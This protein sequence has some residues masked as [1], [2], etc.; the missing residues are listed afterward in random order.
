MREVLAITVCH[1][2][3]FL[4]RLLGRNGGTTPGEIALKIAPSILTRLKYPA[5]Y[6]IVTGTNGKTSV[7]GMIR[8]I[9]QYAG[10][11]VVSNVHGDNLIFGA[12]SAILARTDWNRRVRGDAVVLELDEMTFARKV[13]N[14][15]PTDVVLTNFFRDQLDRCGE[16]ASIVRAV[17]GAVE[18]LQEE[19]AIRV[20]L[21]ADDPSLSAF[22]GICFGMGENRFSVQ[23]SGKTEAAEGRFCPSCS[24]RLEYRYYQY[25]H[26]GDYHC[27]HCGFA[28]RTPDFEARIDDGDHL[29]VCGEDYGRRAGGLYH[30]YNELAA[31]SVARSYGVP[32]SR[33]RESLDSYQKGIGRMEQ[34]GGILL[35]LVKNPTGLNQVLRYLKTRERQA[36]NADAS[37]DGN[38]SLNGSASLNPEIVPEE[39][40]LLFV[41][42]DDRVDGRDVSWIWDADLRDLGVKKILCSGTRAYDIALRFQYEQGG[43]DIVV[44]E[45]VR[46]A[47][48][49]L[50][51]TGG[52]A[53]TTYS[54]LVFVR[55]CILHS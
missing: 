8:S 10:Y 16:M 25:S 9:L 38:G 22:S 15:K 55:N 45:D 48:L 3:R 53:L 49:M 36:R 12:A 17:R 27:R 31:I 52:Y 33:I 46:K 43:F 21:N 50:K 41:L 6:L 28:R 47:V 7:T 5:I 40:A 26:I 1:F 19:G 44:V 51:R 35:N 42:N 29:I 54:A 2:V 14:F 39:R 24:E 20:F 13:R 4:L 23:N 32:A 18:T 37:L 34:L 11:D 30:Y